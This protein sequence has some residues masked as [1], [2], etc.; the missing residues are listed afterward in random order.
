MAESKSGQKDPYIYLGCPR[1]LAVLRL[2][3]LPLS[4][5]F[6]SVCFEKIFETKK[7]GAGEEIFVRGEITGVLPERLLAIKQEITLERIA[8]FSCFLKIKGEPCGGPRIFFRGLSLCY[9]CH[10]NHYAPGIYILDR[11]EKG[12]QRYAVIGGLLPIGAI[13][14]KVLFQKKREELAEA[15][16]LQKGADALIFEQIY[17]LDERFKIYYV[18]PTEFLR[19]SIFDKF[20][21]L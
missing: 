8:S 15:F 14:A 10:N 17:P 3:G 11:P 12:G 2:D 19:P 21:K 9:K 18:W 5:F 20:D 16:F 13:K 4:D 6:C 7:M 1:C